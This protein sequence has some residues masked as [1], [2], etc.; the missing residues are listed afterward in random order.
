MAPSHTSTGEDVGSG[1]EEP[2][3]SVG[4]QH[5]MHASTISMVLPSISL[6]DNPSG[7]TTLLRVRLPLL[8]LQDTLTPWS[9]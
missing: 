1:H 4:M 2:R 6:L 7:G 3:T 9:Q 5:L 8:R